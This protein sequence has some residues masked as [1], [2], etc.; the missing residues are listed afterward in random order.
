MRDGQG[1]EVSNAGAAEIAALDFLNEEWLRYGNRLTE[2]IA[3]ADTDERTPMVQLMAA[4]LTLSMDAPE[5]EAAGRRYLGKAKKISG[6]NARES[7]W[8]AAVDA[9]ASRDAD[10]RWPFISTWPGNG[11]A[12]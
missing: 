5:G 9:W 3:T 12:T 10:R 7:A 8:I 6:A 11:R 1:L 2:F 4:C